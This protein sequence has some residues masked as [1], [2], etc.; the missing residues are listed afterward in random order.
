[1]LHLT[2]DAPGVV[3]TNE[4]FDYELY[5]FAAVGP[6]HI[7]HSLRF[8]ERRSDLGELREAPDA[9]PW[10]VEV[11][12]GAQLFGATSGVSAG[13]AHQFWVGWVLGRDLHMQ[14]LKQETPFT[15]TLLAGERP[16]FP[17]VMDK[18]GRVA[19]YTWR[20]G[21]QGSELWR[22]TFTGDIHQPV[23]MEV[24]G[25]AH[26]RGLPLASRA[27]AITNLQTS[28]AVLGWA[29][30]SDAGTVLGAALIEADQVRVFRSE[31]IRGT[32]PLPRQRV[33]VWALSF[34]CVEVDAVVESREEPLGYTLARFSIGQNGPTKSGWWYES[35]DSVQTSFALAP[36]A[37]QPSLALTP[38]A[39]PAGS[40]HAAALEHLKGRFELSLEQVFL[41]KDGRLL[42]GHKI[43]GALREVRRDVP[44]DNPLAVVTGMQAAYWGTRQPNGSLTLEA[45]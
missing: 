27:A 5:G 13:L 39:L 26:V 16:V 2:V 18:A 43:G 3:T 12:S 14:A 33:G 40:L 10:D 44:L 30:N 29:E 4:R 20:P 17:A 32:S 36:E 25:L 42:Q 45:F 15:T 9:V 34:G 19:V 11:P 37:Q 8:W 7:L 31:P 21:D 38:L 24:V 35:E 41:T 28:H 22:L 23:T 1:M 6:R